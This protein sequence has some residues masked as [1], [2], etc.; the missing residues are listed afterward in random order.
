MLMIG[1]I[2]S[3]VFGVFIASRLAVGALVLAT[4]IGVYAIFSGIVLLMLAFRIRK[5]SHELA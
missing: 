4:W 5:W 3:I 2:L 1:G